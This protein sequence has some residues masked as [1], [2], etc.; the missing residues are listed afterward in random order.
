LEALMQQLDFNSEALERAAEDRILRERRMISDFHARLREHRPDQLLQMRRH[1][2]ESSADCL[3][4]CFK[5]RLEELKRQ[6]EHGSNLLR[7]LAP[8]A[9]LERGYSITRTETGEIVRSTA[10]VKPG[11][12]VSTQVADGVFQSRVGEA[13]A[14]SQ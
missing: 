13:E 5:Q 6:L 8:V 12:A 7:V 11:M 1:Q 2:L 9:T 10:Q 14:D 3:N 4:R